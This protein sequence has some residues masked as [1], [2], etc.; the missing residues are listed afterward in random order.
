M[1]SAISSAIFA[2]RN[3]GKTEKGE[4][5]RAPVAAAQTIGVVDKVTRYNATLAKGTDAAVSV[6]S[7]MA[8]KSK[9]VDGALKAV[10]W[11]VNNVNPLICISGGIKVAMSDDKASS[12]VKEIAALS[13]MFAGE[14]IAKKALPELIKKIPAGTKTGAIIK[15]LGF[16]TASIASYEIGEKIGSKLIKDTKTNFGISTQKINQM[17]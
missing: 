7:N 12:A 4:I 2:Y 15:G 5:G 1:F 10:K 3:V 14:A 6:F 8:Q 16:V 17:A 11:G 13:T 9:V